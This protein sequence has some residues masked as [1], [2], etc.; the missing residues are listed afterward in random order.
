MKLFENEILPLPEGVTMRTTSYDNRAF[1]V[2]EFEDFLKQSGIP[3]LYR[4]LL[5]E[6]ADVTGGT[7]IY[8]AG[9]SDTPYIKGGFRGSG[10]NSLIKITGY[11]SKVLTSIADGLRVQYA[12]R[13]GT[14]MSLTDQEL[15]VLRE[16]ASGA[17]LS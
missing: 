5:T 3:L 4:S 2:I 6:Q 14:E 7:S 12:E 15:S 11:N 17:S 10:L 8:I 16:L 9:F 1:M 13:S